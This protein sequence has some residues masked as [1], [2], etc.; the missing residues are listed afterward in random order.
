M[1]ENFIGFY[2]WCYPISTILACLF[3]IRVRISWKKYYWKGSKV[4]KMAYRASYLVYDYY[5]I[6]SEFEQIITKLRQSIKDNN[7]YM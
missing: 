7:N 6:E 3:S 5:C 1:R 4:A 2:I